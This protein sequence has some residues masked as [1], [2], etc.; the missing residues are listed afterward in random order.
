MMDEMKKMMKMK[1]LQDLKE[2]MLDEMGEG[3]SDKMEGLKKVTV[4]SPTEEGLK[5]GLSKAEEILKGRSMMMPKDKKEDKEDSS[6]KYN[7][8]GVKKKSKKMDYQYP[9]SGIKPKY[10]I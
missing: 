1:M 5:E 3:M 6:D 8:G 7:Y 4:A 2:E 10:P 9:L